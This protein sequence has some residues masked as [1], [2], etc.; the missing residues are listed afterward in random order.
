MYFWDKTICVLVVYVHQS[1]SGQNIGENLGHFPS[2]LI[3]V[4]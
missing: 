4:H 1:F 3:G 2:T